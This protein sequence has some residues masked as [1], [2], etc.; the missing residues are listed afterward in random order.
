MM[1]KAAACGGR[2]ALVYVQHLLG[3]GHLMRIVRVGRALAASGVHVTVAMGGV[4]VD[5]LDMTGL[6]VAQL[7]PVRVAPEAMDQLLDAEGRPFGETR[8]SARRDQLVALFDRLGPDLLIIEA[9]PFGRRQMR[10]ELLPL[11]ARARQAKRQPLVAASIRDILQESSRPGRAEEICDLVERH[12][13]LVLVHGEA[14]VTPLSLTFPLAERIAGRTAY[15]G[16]VGPAAPERPVTGHDVIVS[17]G[18]GAVGE[19]LLAAALGALAAPRFAG[20]R[21][22]ALTGPNMEMSARA[23]LAALAPPGAEVRSFV[24]DL[25]ARLLAARLSVSQAGYNTVADLLVTGCPAVLV[26]FARG[27][28][29]EQTRRAEAMAR[30]GRAILAPEAGLTPAVMEGAIAAGLALPRPAAGRGLDG[31]ARAAALLLERLAS[32]GR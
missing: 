13:D 19:P 7:D 4:Q 1:A 3:I 8:R 21:T 29:T 17:A 6:D 27:G 14:E 28:E 12:F 30:G 32:A 11:L 5:G 2:R 26:P 31:A 25:P 9:F 24:S 16:M 10:F 23:R 15:A 18:G 22:L 20:L